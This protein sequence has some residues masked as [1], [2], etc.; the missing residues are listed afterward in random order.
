MAACFSDDPAPSSPSQRS[1]APASAAG[2]PTDA[3][4][5]RLCAARVSSSVESAALAAQER[6]DDLATQLASKED[7]LLRLEQEGRNDEK[8]AK[9]AEGERRRL[10]DEISAIKGQ[11]GQAETE[12]D[13]ARSELVATLRKLDQQMAETEQAREE[14]ASQRARADRSEWSAFVSDAKTR[15]CDRGSR[16][17]HA[18]C[19][20]AV[21]SA[22]SG[23]FKGRFEA[24]IGTKQAAPELRSLEKDAPLPNFAERVPDDK[25][26]TTKGWMVVFCD[27]SLPEPTPGE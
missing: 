15:I 18:R 12:R 1:P 16:K 22:L 3:D 19:H 21:E 8:R 26:F 4:L 25:D 24:C 10:A 27:P 13:S 14:A 9:A 5:D 6:V 17:R 23:D 20:D 11:L 2:A 7:E